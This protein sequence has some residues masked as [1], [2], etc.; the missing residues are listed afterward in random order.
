MIVEGCSSRR[1]SVW[2]LGQAAKR[3]TQAPLFGL[4]GV[5]RLATGR[6]GDASRLRAQCL[7]PSEAS[8]S[9]GI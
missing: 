3:P 8:L 1:A 2:S 5:R 9:L 4:S 7:E 6:P